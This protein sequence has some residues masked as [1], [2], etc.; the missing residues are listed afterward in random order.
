MEY[1][2]NG[3]KGAF[4]IILDFDREFLSIVMVSVK[5]ACTSTLLAALAGIPFGI[6][7]AQKKFPGRNL[8]ITALN[9]LMSLPTVV[10][11]LTV[12]S[13]LS[14]IGPL[15]K[16]GLL[17]TL[18]AMIIGQFILVFP[19][20]AGLTVATVRSLDNRIKTTL[21]SLGASASQSFKM[22]IHEAR[23][24]VITAF[25]AGFGRV[26][27]EVGVSMMLGGNI[28]G[29]TRNIT[30]A[31]ALETSKG[32]F[33]LGIALGIVLLTVAF[34]INMAVTRLQKKINYDL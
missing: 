26:F 15:G 27:A 6:L 22:F 20:L 4:R 5:V 31:I 33:A 8:V 7:V 25:I 21:V 23:L 11:G 16:L 3:L 19:I 2:I 1:I 12:Y 10:V 32:E 24:G 18:S 34:T 29:Y 9:T 13:F 14:R 30:T 17:Y 28:K